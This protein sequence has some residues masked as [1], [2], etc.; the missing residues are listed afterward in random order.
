MKRYKVL[1]I[2]KYIPHYRIPIFEKLSE[3][4]DLDIIY[5]DE[6]K[7]G[8]KDYTK[9]NVKKIKQIKIPKYGYISLCNFKRIFKKY[10]AVIVPLDSRPRNIS[11][12]LFSHNRKNNLIAWGIGVPASRECTYD[13]DEKRAEAYER[14]VQASDASLFYCDYPVKKYSEKGINPKKLFVANNTV[15]VNRTQYSPDGRDSIL[16][17]GSLYRVKRV[18]ELIKHYYD[19]T[20]KQSEVPTLYI[21]G[22]GEMYS[23]L[24]TL[25]NELH[26][27]D[28]V[29]LVGEITDD[30][31]LQPYFDRA[32]ACISP[33][34]A[35]LSVLQSMGHGVPF[36]TLKDAITGGERFNIKNGETGVLMDSFEN[37][38]DIIQDISNNREKYL[39][40]GKNAYDYYWDNRTPDDMVHGFLKAIDYVTQKEN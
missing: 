2:Q 3:Y 8:I 31:A 15:L 23:E 11:K 20:K 27:S 26:L 19:V 12:I 21:I 14:V 9:L 36:I 7:Q 37:L 28:K 34:Q 29:K 1:L 5:T 18:D 33:N 32:I 13:G 6:S 30:K 22:G 10:D 4:V 40:M 38:S 24:E 35:G 17:L 39:K 16:F 25:I